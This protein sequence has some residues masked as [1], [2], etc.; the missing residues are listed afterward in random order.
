MVCG[1]GF[2]V[3]EVKVSKFTENDAFKRTESRRDLSNIKDKA[4][5]ILT[6]DRA[7]FFV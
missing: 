1:C 5:A 3:I 4:H 6:S 2:I 7:F